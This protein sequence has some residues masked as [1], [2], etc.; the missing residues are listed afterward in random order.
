MA[1][2]VQAGT[3]VVIGFGALVWA[4][5]IAEDGLSWKHAYDAS[6]IIKDQ[7]GATRTKIRMD[8]Y[9]ELSGSFV[10]DDTAGTVTVA[11]SVPAEG[12]VFSITDP[13][14]NAAVYFE[15]MEASAALAAGA[16]KLTMTLRKEASM[17]Y[18]PA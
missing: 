11:N 18:T 9:D 12:D 7:N 5:Y 6:E 14:G 10:I 15:V 17:D 8:A 16:V 4:A 2:P 13:D 1:V 3:D